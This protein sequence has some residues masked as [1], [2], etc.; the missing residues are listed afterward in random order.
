VHDKEFLLAIHVVDKVVMG[1]MLKS[2]VNVL[3][4]F[5]NITGPEFE[6]N[7]AN[8]RT[9]NIGPGIAAALTFLA[10]L[11]WGLYFMMRSDSLLMFIAITVTCIAAMTYPNLLDEAGG[12]SFGLQR[13]YDKIGNFLIIAI[14]VSI[15]LTIAKIFGYK[16]YKTIWFIIGIVFLLPILQSTNL[17]SIPAFIISVQYI[18]SI[19]ISLYMIIKNRK[20]TLGSKRVLVMGFMVTLSGVTLILIFGI[21]AFQIFGINTNILNDGIGGVIFIIIVALIMLSIP[22]GLSVYVVMRFKEM[23]G[24]VETKANE[25]IKVT[26]EKQELL[27]TQN[28]ELEKNV[29]ERT[30]DL[31]RSL[32]DLKSTQ[33][34][35]IHSEKMASL[36]ELTAGIAHEIQNPLNFVNNF[37]E[38]SG[39]LVEEINEEINA[40]NL[41]EAEEITVDLKHNLEK[42]NHHGQ[43]ASGIVKG[44]LEHSR[45]GTGKKEPTDINKLADEYLRLSYHGLRAKD[46][47]FNADFKSDFDETLPE[48]TV[49]VQDLGRVILNLIN[50]A[51]YAVSEKAKAADNDKYKP[52]VKVSTKK[53]STAV[54][55]IVQDN[56]QGIP[57]EIVD[58]IFQPFFTTKPTGSGTGLGLSLSYDLVKAHGGEMQVESIVGDGSK[59]II[60]LPIV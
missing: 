53:L 13:F 9:G 4:G 11:F 35:L 57:Q 41:K 5:I 55:I 7:I 60:K 48:V 14:L 47:S 51:F 19:G 59:F 40:G 29:A 37:S 46:K 26:K 16:I 6:L 3:H 21:V 32:E 52:I 44:M 18:L 36:G 58:K 17:V 30:D 56:G 27:E 49:V 15:P 23:Y 1:G 38:V 12:I 20:Q 31:N 10:L 50:N 22:L 39:E 8:Q 43:R 25:V 2:E 28:Q 54:E 45:T 33:T 34:Q 24:E 42:I